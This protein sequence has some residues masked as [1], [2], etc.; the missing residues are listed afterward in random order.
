LKQIQVFNGSDAI[1]A[2]AKKYKIRTAW[3]TDVL[4]SAETATGQGKM[5]SE[6]STRTR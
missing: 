1:Y 2:L 5:L 4:Y 6:R 3:G